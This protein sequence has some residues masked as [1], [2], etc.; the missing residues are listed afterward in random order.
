VDSRTRVHR[1]RFTATNAAAGLNLG[2]LFGEPL[3]QWERGQLSPW[4]R[5]AGCWTAQEQRCELLGCSPWGQMVLPTAVDLLI[6]RK[7]SGKLLMGVPHDGQA[8]ARGRSVGSKSRDDQPTSGPQGS[9]EGGQIVF[10]L[11]GL[12]EKMVDGAVVPQCEL[13]VH[14]KVQDVGDLE[15]HARSGVAQPVTHRL[16]GGGRE[17]DRRQVAKTPGQEMVD[18][19]GPP[20]AD[21]D[22]RFPWRQVNGVDQAKRQAWY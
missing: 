17:V 21:V 9:F 1:P 15:H 11:V 8:A 13:P 3:G 19:G 18:Q 5:G 20:G 6:A 14:L 4:S 7:L 16:Q 12:G 2:G 22:D 10:P